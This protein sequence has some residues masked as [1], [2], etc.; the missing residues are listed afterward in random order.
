MQQN[1]TPSMVVQK[2]D[3]VVIRPTRRYIHDKEL[4]TPENKRYKMVDGEEKVDA[5]YLVTFPL[6]GHSIRVDEEELNRLKSRLADPNGYVEAEDNG[7][8]MTAVLRAAGGRSLV[9]IIQEGAK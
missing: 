8:D 7:A 5:G 4:S 3:G 9:T 6:K 1:Q 2:L